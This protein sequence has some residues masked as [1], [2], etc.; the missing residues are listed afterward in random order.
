MH[1]WNEPL[2]ESFRSRLA[3]LPHALLIHGA[4]GTGKLALAERIAQL[5][6][7]ESS[8]QR[9]CDRCE[10]CRW[11]LAG[12]HPDFRRV[13]PEILMKEPAVE[14]E[15]A[16][17]EKK[18]KAP[19][20]V[21]KIEQIR[22]LTDFLNIRSHR[23]A[24]RVTILHPAEDLFPNAANAL[25]KALEE[26]PGSA[27][28]ILVSHQPAKLLPTIRSRCVG[29]PVP[30]PPAAVAS[31]WLK[32]QGVTD[33]QRWLAYA[34]GAPLAAIQ[35]AE[36]ADTIDRLLRNP[37]PVDER[38][39]LPRLVEAMQKKAIDRAMAAFGLPPKYG[40]ATSN[41]G[42][43]AAREWLAIA[44]EM[45]ENRALSTHPVNARLFSAALLSRLEKP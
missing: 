29:L 44:R 43:A 40:T 11:F 15:D 22:E 31:Q 3:R 37:S 7:C 30:I 6:L 19:S 23:G 42:R 4:H 39:N 1:P 38:E 18:S 24:R 13:E 16:P 32:E 26:P 10:G 33:A 9:P 36:Q 17:R 8:A 34:G 20:I 21:I 2:L 35:Y 14:D 28:F 12:S 45:G 5:L 41:P 25:L 27:M